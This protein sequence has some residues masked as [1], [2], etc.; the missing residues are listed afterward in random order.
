[1]RYE[2]SGEEGRVEGCVRECEMKKRESGS[3]I[4]YGE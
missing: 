4:I 3:G 2:T 1:M